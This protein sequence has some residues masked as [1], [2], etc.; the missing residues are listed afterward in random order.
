M[1]TRGKTVQVHCKCCKSEFTARVA[2]RKRGWARFCSK[3]CKAI[4]QERRT[5]QFKRYLKY[6]TAME[7]TISGIPEHEF[8][9]LDYDNPF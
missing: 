2:D 8:M 5:G 3:R 4:E 7:E 9:D 1:A 6:R